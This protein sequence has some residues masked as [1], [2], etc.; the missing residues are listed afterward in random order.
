MELWSRALFFLLV[1]IVAIVLPLYAKIAAGGLLVLRFILVW[2]QM[3]RLSRRLSERG[4]LSMYWLY[5]LVA[6]AVE[7]VLAVWRKF[8][9]K[10]KWR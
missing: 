5:D 4:F 10:Y 7:A 6:P 8:V 3:K 1:A 2:W 9:P